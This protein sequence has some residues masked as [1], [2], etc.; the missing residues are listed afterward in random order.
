MTIGLLGEATLIGNLQI[1]VSFV[2]GIIGLLRIMILM[3]GRFI[4]SERFIGAAIIIR[5]I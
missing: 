3:L 1:I 4:T 5:C 2:S